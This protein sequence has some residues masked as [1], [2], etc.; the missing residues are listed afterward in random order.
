MDIKLIP[1]DQSF[2]KTLD[3]H[4]NI[5]INDSG[6]YYTIVSDDIKSG[7][8]GYIPA[9][10][11]PQSGFVQIIIAKDFRGM[12]ILKIAEDL[13]AE[14]HNLKILYATI[15]KGNKASIISHLKSGFKLISDDRLIKLRD[16][17]LLKENEIRL[18]KVYL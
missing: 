17:D 8:V 9:K 4:E 7:I 3:D 1:F 5:V 13:L 18:E 15:A 10:F 14:K 16:D 6:V 2:L 12:G 11:P